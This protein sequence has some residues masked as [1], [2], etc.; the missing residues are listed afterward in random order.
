MTEN[1]DLID[2]KLSLILQ[3]VQ[4]RAAVNSAA[5]RQ[6]AMRSALE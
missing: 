3:I 2:M 1:Y 5:L 6:S 4:K